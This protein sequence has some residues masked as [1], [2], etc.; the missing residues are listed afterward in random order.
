ML[1]SISSASFRRMEGSRAV[2]T[3]GAWQLKPSPWL[4]LKMITIAPSA[5]AVSLTR[6]QSSSYLPG[7]I[8]VF[9][10]WLFERC[11]VL[12]FF[13]SPVIFFVVFPDPIGMPFTVSRHAGPVH[14]EQLFGRA[15][16]F[17]HLDDQIYLDP[18]PELLA[19]SSRSFSLDKRLKSTRNSPLFSS[20]SSSFSSAESASS[21]ITKSCHFS[22]WSG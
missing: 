15:V 3:S 14:R 10:G 20:R 1:F 19:E 4:P 7:P 12:A 17:L 16:L 21:A 9:G 6:V 11:A 8:M 22:G 13:L 5:L 2:S 18:G